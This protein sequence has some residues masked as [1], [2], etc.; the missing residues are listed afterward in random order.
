MFDSDQLI[1]CRYVYLLTDSFV[2]RLIG[3]GPVEQMKL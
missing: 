1:T 3:Q 2:S